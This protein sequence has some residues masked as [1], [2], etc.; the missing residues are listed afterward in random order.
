LGTGRDAGSVWGAPYEPLVGLVNA[1]SGKGVLPTTLPEIPHP[2]PLLPPAELAPYPYPVAYP[3]AATAELAAFSTEG[4]GPV[5]V[6]GV[7]INGEGFF[8]GGTNGFG[9]QTLGTGGSGAFDVSEAFASKGFTD[10]TTL[11]RGCDEK[12]NC[13]KSSACT[14]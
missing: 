10:V 14:D 4:P 11:G 8:T 6:S 7:R 9:S 13:C 5:R 2:E 1:Y 3:C 12:L